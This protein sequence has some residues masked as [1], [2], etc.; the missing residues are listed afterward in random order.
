VKKY[1][2]GNVV[3]TEGEE[4]K[5]M[6][7]ADRTPLCSLAKRQA[8]QSFWGWPGFGNLS[9]IGEEAK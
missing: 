9:E 1:S 6:V 5:T 8:K 4:V 7:M 2:V 3:A